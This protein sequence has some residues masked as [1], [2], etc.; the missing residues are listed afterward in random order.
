MRVV[1]Y[2]LLYIHSY[3]LYSYRTLSECQI[4]GKEPLTV[5]DNVNGIVLESL[6]IVLCLLRRPL[7]VFIHQ[8]STPL[9]LDPWMLCVPSAKVFAFQQNNSTAV[10]A[11]KFL[12]RHYLHVLRD[13]KISFLEIPTSR[14]IFTLIYGNTTVLWYLPLLGQL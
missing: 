1:A 11:V 4:P 6:H 7:P 5:V 8:W 13:C 2:L 10:S 9:Q 3:R 14:V 12:Y